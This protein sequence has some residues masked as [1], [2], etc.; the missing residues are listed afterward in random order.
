M[1]GAP[2]SLP[3]LPS[4]SFPIDAP[5]SSLLLPPR[6]SFLFVA[7]SS[8]LPPPQS[9][10]LPRSFLPLTL[11]SSHETN[12]LCS[13]VWPFE[14]RY[15]DHL[16]NRIVFQTRPKWLNFFDV[17]MWAYVGWS[18]KPGPHDGASFDH[19]R[20]P[21]L[22]LAYIFSFISIF[23][24]SSWIWPLMP[25][26]KKKIRAFYL[27]NATMRIHKILDEL[28]RTRGWKW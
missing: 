26:W 3:F 27:S 16:Q 15:L 4:R 10:L 24:P 17:N 9:L 21:L 14:R 6:R 12:W 7:P 1:Q 23:Y 18:S 28:A 8:S 13:R 2:C 5:S 11:I 20:Q 19:V 22:C 25:L